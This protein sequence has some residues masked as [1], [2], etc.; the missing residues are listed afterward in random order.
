MVGV[1]VEP[2]N[3]AFP[4]A[5][6]PRVYL[7]LEDVR[8]EIARGDGSDVNAA[9]LTVRDRD[10]LPETLVQARTASYGTSGLTFTTR[11]GVRALV[12]EAGG[13]V[14]GLLVAFA[15]V[16][17]LATAAMLASSAH[18]RVTRDLQTIGALRAIGWTPFGL[19][20][21][22]ALEAVLVALP[23][24]AVGVVAG[25]LLVRGPTDDLLRD[26]NE[27]SPGSA[28][29]WP[30]VVVIAGVVLLAGLASAIPAY[31]AA[32]R[33]VVETLRGGRTVR[34]RRS[35][36]SG[37]PILLGARLAV[38]RPG[39][40]LV[41]AV[42]I[43]AAVATVLLLLALARFLVDA[44]R[45]PWAIGER[46][47]LLVEDAA[48][49]PRVLATPGVA[50]AAERL[51]VRGVDAFD[52]GSPLTVVAFGREGDVFAGRPLLEGRRARTDDEVEVGRGLAQALGLAPGGRLVAELAGGGELRLQV[53]GVVQELSA[54]G[55][56]AYASL[57]A[58]RAAAPGA[59]GAVAVRPEAGVSAA[60]LTRRLEARGLQVEA[61]AGL[62]PA[63]AP[64]V[65][66]IVALLRVV[67]AVTGLVCGAIVLLSLVVLARERAETIA[68][69]RTCGARPAQVVATLLGAA[70]VLLLLAVPLGYALE[71]L[72]FGPTLS[73]VAARY[74]ALPLQP[75][76]LELAGVLAGAAVLASL[77]AAATG[78]RLARAPIVDVLR[79][80]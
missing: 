20:L 58:L 51:E 68:V 28:V 10:R 47:A 6:R 29:G 16:A 79:T 49:L 75:S 33:P 73:H 40:L 36:T 31:G 8:R 65:D 76:A 74:G 71:R 41:G 19:A 44:Q 53:V 38:S 42:A 35:G 2:D 54:D 25:A 12:D 37:R 60:E 26:L 57:A 1:A 39:R 69:L 45:E 80:E 46:Y 9:Y 56:V 5:A 18:A 21:S 4:L 77:A 32:R 27:L 13:L 50:A 15:V 22:Y 67:A 62:A 78:A 43:A 14:G 23:A 55:R 61:N 72:V 63:G 52:L 24:A 3:V 66:T 7:R 17:L 70:L 48:S 30:H 59:P 64:F 34:P 11:D